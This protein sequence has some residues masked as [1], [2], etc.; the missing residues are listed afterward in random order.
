MWID[1]LPAGLLIVCLA[2]VAVLL[3]ELA[4]RLWRVFRRGRVTRPLNDV[5]YNIAPTDV[6]LRRT[7]V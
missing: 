7:E 1:L 2:G 6:P 4:E 3:T 5:I